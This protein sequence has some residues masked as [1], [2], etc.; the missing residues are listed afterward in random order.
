MHINGYNCGIHYS[1]EQFLQSHLF[2][3]DSYHGSDVV[4]W[5]IGADNVFKMNQNFITRIQNILQ[6]YRHARAVFGNSLAHLHD[7]TLTCVTQK[8][9]LVWVRRRFRCIM[10][11]R[12]ATT[13]VERG[14]MC[15]DVRYVNG[16]F[17]LSFVCQNI[18]VFNMWLWRSSDTDVTSEFPDNNAVMRQ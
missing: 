8:S 15:V 17:L 2:S 10:P 7:T 16:P 9:K 11:H 12:V 13:H 14:M 3:P 4:Y 18:Y 6:T 1:T 5:R